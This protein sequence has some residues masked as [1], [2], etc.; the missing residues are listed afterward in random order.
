[1]NELERVLKNGRIVGGIYRMGFH[2]CDILTHD[3]W[4]V[5]AGGIAHG[6][7]LLSSPMLVT[8]AQHRPE[9]RYFFVLR[10]T[11][12]GTLPYES[13]LEHTRAHAMRKMVTTEPG[14]SLHA[15]RLDEVLT[16]L[17]ANEISFGAL[18]ARILGTLREDES[19]KIYFRGDI[20][21]FVTSSH[22]YVYK[23]GRWA[24]DKIVNHHRKLPTNDNKVSPFRLGTYRETASKSGEI[25]FLVNIIDFISMKTAVLGM[26]RL[27]KSNTLKMLALGTLVESQRR[28]DDKVGQLIFDPTGEYAYP[29]G[30]DEKTCVAQVDPSVVKIYTSG[31][32]RVPE[33]VIAS[34]LTLNVFNPDDAAFVWDLVQYEL[35]ERSSAEYIRSFL[36]HPITTEVPDED[37]EEGEEEE[38][39]DEE[40]GETDGDDE[41]ADVHAERQAEMFRSIFYAMLFRNGLSAPGGVKTFVR[42]SKEARE[43]IAEKL[44][45]PLKE[46]TKSGKG[47]VALNGKDEHIQ[48]WEAVVQLAPA[49]RNKAAKDAFHQWLEGGIWDAVHFWKT[50]AGKTNLTRLKDYH[51]PKAEAD[52]R[53]RIRDDLKEGRLVIIDV[54]GMTSDFGAKLNEFIVKYLVAENQDDFAKTQNPPRIQIYIE[55]AHKFLQRPKELA[56]RDRRSPWVTLAKEAAKL[57]IGLVYATQEPTS[58]DPEIRNNTANWIVTRLNNREELSLLGKYEDFEDF[59]A[60]IQRTEEIGFAR[61]KTASTP[62][63]VAVQIDKFDKKMVDA[64]K[65]AMSEGW[66]D[67]SVQDEG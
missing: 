46:R 59:L 10:V 40:E 3:L 35:Q 60:S 33:G 8:D 67:W 41:G 27:G 17:V 23:P 18:Q 2:D 13:D 43:K 1:M 56:K 39:E 37:E 55:E 7:I 42:S 49:S 29:T 61:V 12:H 9:N 48:F 19:G 50:G 4:K 58:V 24:L 66:P 38:D 63:T 44:K 34:R 32:K 22:Y 64:A 5:R 47:G 51:D 14:D 28:A 25:P 11:E 45:D 16:K 57:R 52:F 31:K 53:R 6:S 26:T 20:D 21:N 15:K 54:S 65:K 30:Q 36:T 62:L